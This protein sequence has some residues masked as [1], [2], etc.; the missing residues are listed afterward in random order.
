MSGT[1]IDEPPLLQP[2]RWPWSTTAFASGF[3]NFPCNRLSEKLTRDQGG[4]N[5]ESQYQVEEI[6]GKM[7]HD[8]FFE[9]RV[10]RAISCCP[11]V[12]HLGPLPPPL[13]RQPPSAMMDRDRCLIL[14]LDIKDALFSRSPPPARALWVHAA[15]FVIP[16]LCACLVGLRDERK[17]GRRTWRARK[18]GCEKSILWS[19]TGERVGSMHSL[20]CFP[21]SWCGL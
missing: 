5:S 13:L 17:E 12:D 14:S 10:G 2:R 1:V 16:T 11:D 4:E 19:E 20:G 9:L 7:H 21:I 15:S 3:Q 8:S 18:S 6:S